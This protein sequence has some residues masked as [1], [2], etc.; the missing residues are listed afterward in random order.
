MKYYDFEFIGTAS[1][2]TAGRIYASTDHFPQFVESVM[3]VADFVFRLCTVA[4]YLPRRVCIAAH[5]SAHGIR[6][7]SDFISLQT[8]PDHAEAFKKLGLLMLPSIS[9]L[10]LYSCEVGQNDALLKR[11]SQTLGGA[12][13][14]AYKEKQPASGESNGSRISCTLKSCR[15]FQPTERTR[16][17]G[18]KSKVK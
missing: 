17:K 14:V 10:E 12:P 11:V 3:Q 1:H 2:D 13:V 7:G 4:D 5:G 8:F 15:T 16:S 9:I 18:S 6:I